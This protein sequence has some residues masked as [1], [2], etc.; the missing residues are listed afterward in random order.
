MAIRVTVYGVISLVAALL[1]GRPVINFLR[2]V[3]AGATI[4][5][6]LSA[7]HQAKVGTPLMGG[8]IFLIPLLVFF[9]FFWIKYP[10]MRHQIASVTLFT[11]GYSLI[12]FADD[13]LKI[14]K[15]HSAGLSAKNKII[16]QTLIFIIFVILNGGRL[17]TR[18]F[19]PIVNYS[20]DLGLLYY[21]FILIFVIGFANAVNLTDGMDGLL[22][23]CFI[24]TS[25]AYGILAWKM[26]NELLLAITA[27]II[28]ALIG[29][30]RF[31]YHPAK[32]FMGDTGSLGLG[33]LLAAWA[34]LTK[35]EVLLIII[36]LI[37]V[38]EAFSVIIQV[39]YFKTTGGKRVFLM[40][41]IHHHF[42]LKGIR[43]VSV[44]HYFWLFSF[45]TA[46][47]GIAIY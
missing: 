16:A 23:G 13:Y 3:K 6:E 22:A 33:G 12:G 46:M 35:T 32:V 30:L 20:L 43:E 15:L 19:F 40:A 18:L 5:E 11:V 37:Y 14:V 28:G 2:K 4:Q 26:Q 17:D 34:L 31:N 24:S 47:V 45:I 36:G 38:I 44:V 10:L 29:Y 9:I 42:A 21:P 7:E 39:V 8:I 25:L 27:V 1:L 41:P